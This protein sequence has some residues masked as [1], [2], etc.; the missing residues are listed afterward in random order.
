M[1]T[2]RFIILLTAVSL[3]M[4]AR[5]VSVLFRDGRSDYTIVLSPQA[6]TPERTAAQE[7]QDYLQRIGGAR[8]PLKATAAKP[9]R[10]IYIGI[11]PGGTAS[12]ST[13]DKAKGEESVAPMDESF[14]YQSRGDDIYIYG[15]SPRGTMY[16]VYAFLE[17]EL[18]VR[19]YAP[20]C[21]LVPKR[22]EWT[23]DRLNRHE[24]PAIR[25]RLVQYYHVD[26]DPGWCAHNR[27]NTLWSV[28]DNQY[29]GAEAYWNAHTMTQFVAA[30]DYF[31]A[32]PEYFAMRGGKRVSNGQLCLTNPD[33]LK[34]CTDKLLQAIKEHPGY[35]VYS[36]SQAD[37]ELMCECAECT[38]LL[39][40]YGAQSGIVLWFVNQAADVVARQYPDKYVGT[41]AYRYTR[42]VPTGIKP[43]GNV[44]IRLC[45]IEC[46]FAHPL[47]A[48]CNRSFI[49]DLKAWG[50]IA[51][52]I[53][54][55]D[56]VVNFQQYIAPFPNFGVLASNIRT[57]RDN[58]AIGVHEEA[59]YETQGGEWAELRAW[60][61][62][63]LL[64]N[65]EQD[66]NRLVAEFIQAYYGK[67][68]K[69]VQQYFNLSQQLVKNDHHIGIYI[70]D[71]DA[72]YNDAFI[73]KARTI[74]NKARK[75]VAGDDQMEHRVD[76]V[77]MQIT[78]LDV[79][80]HPK[81]AAANGTMRELIDIVRTNNYQ[82]GEGYKVEQFVNNITEKARQ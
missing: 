29:G 77:K 24:E 40:R 54:I 44:I 76:V 34:I 22:N 52:Q 13:A 31:R 66:T 30:K 35:F 27:N 45:S 36:L 61:L 14:T 5:A 62:A 43:R 9:A 63:K 73:R 32:H 78:Y 33:V 58:G 38:K 67:A 64:W 47:T 3:F 56:Y 69:Y 59:Q 7:F 23:F 42:S 21:T 18:G 41:F 37:N 19:W 15:G 81:Q 39:R 12:T 57:F 50:K 60:V 53:F 46:C 75:A 6:S 16:G 28:R 79:M 72:L 65:P 4:E 17:N 10:A 55:W 49:A 51:P 82:P 11:T 74:L 48:E 25:Y 70:R 68:A 2:R 1:Y 71:N 26:I 20:E 8:L 80:R